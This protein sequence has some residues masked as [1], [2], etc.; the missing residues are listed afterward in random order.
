MYIRKRKECPTHSYQHQRIDMPKR[1][2][3]LF[4]PAQ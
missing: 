1:V 4:K 2:G 3:Q